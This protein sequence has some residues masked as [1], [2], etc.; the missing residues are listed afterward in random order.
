VETTPLSRVE[1]ADYAVCLGPRSFRSVLAAHGRSSNAPA[2][3]V[4]G[5]GTAAGVM[6]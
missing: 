3:I 4:V 1:V 6:L 5:S 2:M